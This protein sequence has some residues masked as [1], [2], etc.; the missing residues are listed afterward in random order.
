MW[1]STAVTHFRRRAMKTSNERGAALVLVVVA[2]IFLIILTGAAYTYF[3]NSVSTQLW[4]RERIQAK[5][6]AEAGVNLGIHKLVAGAALPT[7][8]EPEPILGTFGSF[9]NLP[10]NMGSVFVTV[11]PCNENDR[12]TNAN[13][14]RLR[15]IAD[16]PG[17]TV[18]SNYG[19]E[20]IVMPENLARF[21]VFMDSPDTTGYYAD[22]YRFDGPFYG[23]GPISVYSSSVSGVNDPFFYSLHLTSDYYIYGNP[24]GPHASAPAVGNLE[25]QPYNRLSMGSPYFEMGIDTIPFGKNELDWQGVRNAAYSGG[26]VLSEAANQIE[27]GSRL[28]LR[29]DSTLVVKLHSGGPETSYDLSPSSID[30]PVVWLE[31]AA[32]HRVYLS[33]YQ[34]DYWDM[35]LT[36]GMYGSLYMSGELKY[37]NSDLEDPDNTIIL[38]LISV[39]GDMIIADDP[40]SNETGWAGFQIMTDHAFEYDAVL[41]S[42]EG[43]LKAEDYHAPDPMAEFLLLGG[44]MIDSEGYTGTGDKGFD[45]SVYFDPRLLT[46]HPP[47]FPTTAN[48]L[49]TM[50]AD[51][52]D[53]TAL[54]V[55]D[56]LNPRY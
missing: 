15:C 31:N 13:A 21:S 30:N 40:D 12:V 55:R 34:T 38:G 22:G 14:F 48:W 17:A 6:S 56:G 44:Y 5:L 28:V 46:M 37:E 25:M 29:G 27:D 52:P 47:F 49:N 8:L 53:M 41:V 51:K 26:L 1:A 16:V 23:N 2:S 11:D 45:I 32:S 54:Q 39:D 35:P 33:G 10:G 20:A 9:E 3:K 42:L 18:I 24:N 7:S 19:M 43:V 50:W 36:V 4:T